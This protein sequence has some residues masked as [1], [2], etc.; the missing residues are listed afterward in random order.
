[1]RDIV[2]LTIILGSLPLCFFRPYFGVLM[3]VWVAYFNP[4]RFGYYAY[5]FPVATAI[6]IPTLIGMVFSRQINRNI[7]VRET[8]L[9]VVFWMWVTITWI[10]ATT[11]P[12]FADHVLDGKLRLITTSKVILMSFVILLLVNSRKKLDGLFLVT[13]LSF[14]LLAIKGGIFGIRTSGE[15]RVWG[16]P[17]SFVADNNDFGLALNMTL[18]IMFYMARDIGSKWLKRLLWA[19]FFFSVLAIILTYSRGALLGLA[20]VLGMFTWK[21]RHRMLG[22]GVLAGF[23]LLVITFAPGAWMD[24]MGNFLHGNLDESAEGRLNAWHFAI[25]L[26]NQYPITGGGFE[27][28]QPELFDRFTPGLRFAGP[29]SIYFE[30]LGE[31]GY[32][33]LLI[34]LTTLGSCFVTLRRLR[35]Q[36]RDKPSLKWIAKYSDMLEICLLAYAI[37][38]AFLPRAYFDLWFELAVCTALLKIFYRREVAAMALNPEPQQHEP[39]VLPE[40]QEAPV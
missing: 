8:I 37:S 23:A 21:S 27:T 14:G 4:H 16:P 10:N 24:R 18:P 7:W 15:F 40:M 34:L 2:I 33:G 9:L 12:I 17:D 11:V 28:F 36:V 32:V 6:A 38:G 35:R 13:A 39:E 3:W 22:A 25:V 29:H 1:M 5:N 20:V 31:Q 26:A 30:M 19:S